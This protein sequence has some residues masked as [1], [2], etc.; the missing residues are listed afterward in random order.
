VDAKL[1]HWIPAPGRASIWR[2]TLHIAYWK[3]AV[4]RR[5]V[6]G[7][8]PRFPRT[9]ANFP[10]VPTRA[11]EA[12]WQADRAL[13]AEEHRLLNAV[14][15]DFDHRHLDRIPGG[16]KRWTY[17]ETLIGIAMH[18]AYHTGQIQLLKRLGKSRRVGG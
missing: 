3:Y 11:D 18:D 1:A 8:L 14:I 15:A 12:L 17:G 6:D 2:L 4:R 7:P 5:L 16:G 13:L 9:P 10:A